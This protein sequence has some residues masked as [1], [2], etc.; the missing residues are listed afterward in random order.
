MP[1]L[2]YKSAIPDNVSITSSGV[3]FAARLGKKSPDWFGRRS[4]LDQGIPAGKSRLIL[5]A[6]PVALDSDGMFR[7]RLREGNR[8]LHHDAIGRSYK[9]AIYGR[10]RRHSGK[11][12]PRTYVGQTAWRPLALRPVYDP[13]NR[14]LWKDLSMGDNVLRS[15]RQPGALNSPLNSRFPECYL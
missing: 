3:T 13:I 15:C 6:T 12:E 5:S 8:E 4:L 9:T 2:V 11:E 1:R 14:D 7:T 10:H